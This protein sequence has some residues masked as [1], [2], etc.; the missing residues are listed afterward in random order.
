MNYKDF[1]EKFP[2]SEKCWKGYKQVPNCVKEEELIEKSPTPQEIE[3]F[4]SELDKLVHDTFGERPEEK[5]CDEK[6]KES[7]VPSFKKKQS[8]DVELN[9]KIENGTT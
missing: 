2:L 9:P 3:T 7:P 8:K 1:N 6:K 5:K 4:H